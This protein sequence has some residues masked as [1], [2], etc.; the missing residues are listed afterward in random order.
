MQH[1]P[2]S[3]LDDPH[4]RCSLLSCCWGAAAALAEVAH[5]RLRQRSTPALGRQ[6]DAFVVLAGLL[7]HMTML[8]DR[9]VD[10][11]SFK[12]LWRLL[13]RR[14][15]QADALTRRGVS[16]EELLPLAEPQPADRLPVTLWG[17]GWISAARLAEALDGIVATLPTPGRVD[18][19]KALAALEAALR[20]VLAVRGRHTGA[21]KAAIQTAIAAFDRADTAIGGD[22]AAIFA[23][24]EGCRPRPG[25]AA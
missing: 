22:V 8:A 24:E 1:P 9:R 10:E 25:L 3:K 18:Q 7:D 12:D 5:E 23:E 21:R 2:L 17:L 4:N 16:L 11:A 15:G 19:A 14:L 6:A 13:T 20:H